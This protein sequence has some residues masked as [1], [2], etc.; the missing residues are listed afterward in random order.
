MASIGKIV[1]SSVTVPNEVTLAAAAFNLDFSLIKVEAPAEYNG[2][3]NAL[4]SYR[5]NQ[6]EGGEHHITARRLGALFEPLIPQIPNLTRAYGIRASEIASATHHNKPS[7]PT[8]GIFSEQAGL[9]GTNIWAAATS[10]RGAFAVHFLACLLARI[11][12]NPPEA[13]SIWVEI[14]ERRKQEITSQ[15]SGSDT[16]N[17]SSWNASQQLFTRRQLAAWDSSARSWLQTAD[18]SKS[19]Q[20]TQ[21]TLIT[22]NL[23]IPVN[24]NPDLYKSVLNAWVSA[25]SAMDRMVQ[26]IPQRVQ[27]GAILVAIAS[28][29]LYPDMEVLIDGSKTILQNDPLVK[30]AILTISTQG[31]GERDGVF[32]SLP[33]SRLRYYSPPVMAE[34]RLASDTGRVTMGEFHIVILGMVIESWVHK[35]QD[36]S[37]HC[38]LVSIIYDR[39]GELN[40]EIPWFSIIAMAAKS[41]MESTGIQKQHAE[42]L[43]SLGMRHSKERFLGEVPLPLFGLR[44]WRE[45]FS[46]LNDTET[47]IQ[48]CRELPSKLVG[49]GVDTIIRY[50]HE[51]PGQLNRSSSGLEKGVALF[52][53]MTPLPSSLKRTR[54]G[55]QVPPRHCRFAQGRQSSTLTP[56]NQDHLEPAETSR[57]PISHSRRVPASWNSSFDLNPNNDAAHLPAIDLSEMNWPM[58]CNNAP[59]QQECLPS[60]LCS[61]C[62]NLK[63]KSLAYVPGEDFRHISGESHGSSSFTIKINGMS[64]RY[65]YLLGDTRTIAVFGS[66]TSGFFELVRRPAPVVI[67]TSQLERLLLSPHLDTSKLASHLREFLKP[68]SLFYRS[69]HSLSLASLTYKGLIGASV[70]LSILKL[71][72]CKSTFAQK[73]LDVPACVKRHNEKPNEAKSG[74]VTKL[75]CPPEL[76]LSCIAMFESGKFDIDPLSLRAA[77]ALAAGDSI[78]VSDALLSD[79]SSHISYCGIRRVLGNVGRPKMAFLVPPAAPKLRESD[80]T[81]W[82]LINHEVFDGKFTNSFSDTTLHLSFTGY[83]MP[84]DVGVR[85]LCDSQAVVLESLISANDRGEHVGDLDILAAFADSKLTVMNGCYHHA[86]NEESHEDVKSRCQEVLTSLDCWDEFFDSPRSVG[87]FRA[88]NN[89]Q[90]RLAATA[91]SIQ[92][93]KR[94]LVLPPR[95]CLQCLGKTS[96]IRDFDLIIG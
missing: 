73:C 57:K 36:I 58:A 95:P 26:E 86:S 69:M 34:G 53:T 52:A 6:A 17:I 42:K 65:N 71:D 67:D 41:Y 28:W 43:L 8:L 47:I 22:D 33:L 59:I 38:C 32:W 19:L 74:V 20:Q 51:T 91:A 4:T 9:D 1:V 31:T 66:K 54:E 5:R 62:H 50:H 15:M 16:V 64:R 12:K 88:S 56:S 10:G 85:G 81:K 35:T 37:Q 44:D 76:S 49:E 7:Q 90:A 70:N 45:V 87:I 30:G 72:L 83:E 77:M 80:P 68:D 96:K 21:F 92:K 48:F 55:S 23:R 29:H 11:W 78:Y 63:V 13:I 75:K 14:V 82:Q 94:T 18:T 84:L 93:G 46:L 61:G 60:F 25:M 24:T 27:D 3:R 40:S 89:W 79:P 39:L 2:V